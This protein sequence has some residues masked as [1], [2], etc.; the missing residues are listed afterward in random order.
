MKKLGF[1]RIQDEPLCDK[2]CC[3][4]N[5]CHVSLFGHIARLYPDAITSPGIKERHNSP[6]RLRDDDDNDD[7]VL[8]IM[9]RMMLTSANM[10]THLVC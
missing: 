8:M 5:A 7:D 2:I 4:I 10:L 6:L 3:C 9:I 1:G